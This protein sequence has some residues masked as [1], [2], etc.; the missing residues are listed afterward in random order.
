MSE[1]ATAAWY[2]PELTGG[3]GGLRTIFAMAD[4]LRRRGI[5]TKIYLEN[6]V[7]D[8]RGDILSRFGYAFDEVHSAWKEDP[9]A[10]LAIATVW[11][12]AFFVAKLR[13]PRKFY[14]AQDCEAHFNPVGDAY[15][16][17]QNSYRLGLTI[18][19]MGRWL[20]REIRE[21]CGQPCRAVDFGADE[22]VYFPAPAAAATEAKGMQGTGG[23]TGA[24]KH[25]T[26][27]GG[28]RKAGAPATVCFIHQPEKP[29]RCS[30]L[31]CAA[32]SI[33][34]RAHP[35]V[36]ISLYGS[37]KLFSRRP[38]F[39]HRNLGLLSLDK[40]A[41]LYRRST[42]G[43]CL[44]ATNP[45]RIPFEMMACGLPVV[46]IH[47][48]NNLHDYP[49]GTVTL[50]Q[51]APESLAAAMEKLIRNPA[52]R[53][54]RSQASAAFMQARTREKEGDQFADIILAALNEN[55][56]PPAPAITPFGVTRQSPLRKSYFT[57]MRMLPP[58]LAQTLDQLFRSMRVRMRD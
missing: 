38:G 28:A 55:P 9:D 39:P 20:A 42:V 21:Q 16:A 29:R 1:A 32:L 10:D 3:S 47:R 5:R 37:P 12:S 23:A 53:T 45:S 48:E 13:A 4:A 58:R 30:A 34:K 19:T 33:L 41:E 14:F 17:V 31:G 54:Q 49:A 2:V 22:A 40:C 6:S 8:G 44:S 26:G 27:A 52:L 57:F 46:D 24:A 50:A 7:R 43:L 56:Q 35:E 15:L 36:G 25:E 51:P 11:Y 18:I